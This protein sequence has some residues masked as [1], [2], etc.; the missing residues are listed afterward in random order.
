GNQ[1]AALKIYGQ[2]NGMMKRFFNLADV[3]VQNQM[4]RE[5]SARD[6]QARS[7]QYIEYILFGFVGFNV[8]CAV[9]LAVFF[10]INTKRRL[11]VVMENS[12]RLGAGK[13]LSQ[14]LEGNDELAQLDQVFRQMESAI[15]EL[16]QKERATIENAVDVICSIDGEARFTAVSPS[17]EKVWGYRSEDLLGTRIAQILPADDAAATIQSIRQIVKEKTQGKFESRIKREDGTLVDTLWSAQWSDEEKAL[18]CVAH[19]ITERKQIE[20]LKQDFVAMVSHDL[21]T[22]LTSVQAFLEL[23]SVDAYGALN[24][25]GKESLE[26]TESSVARLISLI[27]DLLDIEK[28]E[29]GMLELHIDELS[30]SD[31]VNRSV[32]AVSSFANSQGV[33]IATRED[34]DVDF[35]ADEDRLVQVVVNL[36]S[37]A[38]KF[39]PKGEAV[40][41]DVIDSQDGWVEV[42]IIDRGRGVPLHLRESIF[43]RF[44]QVERDD[45]RKKGGSG[46]GLAI[47]KAIIDQHGG[48]IGVTDGNDGVGS[49]FWF[50]LPKQA[51]PLSAQASTTAAGSGASHGRRTSG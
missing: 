49:K 5:Q 23:L 27:N 6:A 46:L 51:G 7:R 1:L 39:S 25:T 16:R 4:D 47:C 29:S 37:N 14:P 8:L 40:T 15:A 28:M 9:F 3:I 17:A 12:V 48:S 24:D 43:E 22:P 21:R 42:D 33:K 32:H 50:K 2:M 20:R 34:I 36:L 11:D 10:H 18:Y 45:S 44:K 13:E 30:A 41:I 35:S 31:L 38:I 26:M 19:D